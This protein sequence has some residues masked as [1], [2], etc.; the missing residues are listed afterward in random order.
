MNLQVSKDF[1]GLRRICEILRSP[2]GCS[3]D[4]AQTVTSVTPYL[5]EETHELL[6]AI[7]DNQSERITEE[8]G[9]LLYL[10]LLIATMGA[11]EKRF[12]FDDVTAGIIEKL[13]RRHPH[14]FSDKAKAL[15]HAQ[16]NEQWEQIK[17]K[18]KENKPR[19]KDRLA[20]GTASLPALLDAFRVQGKAASYGFDWPE[21]SQV[22]DKLTEETGEFDEAVAEGDHESAKEE[23]GD[24]L[25]TAVNLAR[26]LG[27]DPEQLL[28]DTT[29]K[30]RRR[31]TVMEE[32]L[33]A[34]GD[35]LA[36]ADLDTME[37]AWQAAKKTIPPQRSDA[38]GNKK[39]S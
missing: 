18:E 3:W 19:Q 34:N 15:S 2:E 10:V 29:R 7:S 6:E 14:V 30:F 32:E 1:D 37:A 16:A 36:D 27:A 26:H 39:R 24:L 22:R 8:M 33:I 5:L 9:D 31:F 13:I 28:R 17:K 4:R 23:L 12:T 25:F 11:E 35:S 38:D 21:L 20:G